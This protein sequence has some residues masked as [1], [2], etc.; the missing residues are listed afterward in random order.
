MGSEM[1]IRDRALLDAESSLNRKQKCSVVKTNGIDT[2]ALTKERLYGCCKSKQ[3]STLF[4]D[5]KKRCSPSTT[6][7]GSPVARP[8][9]ELAR[10]A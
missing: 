6:R 7:T 1:C 9:G 5:S 4:Y 3:R 2:M 8:L 10:S